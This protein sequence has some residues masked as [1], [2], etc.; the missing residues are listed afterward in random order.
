[1]RLMPALPGLRAPFAVSAITISLRSRLGFVPLPVHCSQSAVCRPVIGALWLAT[2][3]D[4]PVQ[5]VAVEA[6]I[7]AVDQ[8]GRRAIGEAEHS[9]AGSLGGTGVVENIG[10]GAYPAHF[11]AGEKPRNVD[12][13]GDLVE[14]DAAAE[15]RVE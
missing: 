8:T 14:Q 2:L 15:R 4:P 12:L 13:V 5:L 1:M 9:H 10:H 3:P 7:A 6:V 11:G